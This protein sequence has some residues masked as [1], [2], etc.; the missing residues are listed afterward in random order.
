MQRLRTALMVSLLAGCH[1]SSPSSGTTIP[2]DPQRPGD[3]QKGYD[4]L[5]NNGYVNCGIPW[6]V[7]QQY[8]SLIL[9]SGPTETIP[10]RRGDNAQLPYWFTASTTASGVEVVAPNCLTCHAGHI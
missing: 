2:A 1:A 7:F 5:V 4:A 10:G 3:A 9:G 8:S 6:S